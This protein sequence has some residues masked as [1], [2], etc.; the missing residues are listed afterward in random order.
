M[1]CIHWGAEIVGGS[2]PKVGQSHEKTE[3]NGERGALGQAYCPVKD[4]ISSIARWEQETVPR[5]WASAHL[6]LCM[7][8]IA[9]VSGEPCGRCCS[10]RNEHHGREGGQ[11]SVWTGRVM[12]RQAGVSWAFSVSAGLG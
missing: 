9:V 8:A 3:N 1:G 6:P 4:E 11:R 12:G 2:R 7:F 5:R 10:D